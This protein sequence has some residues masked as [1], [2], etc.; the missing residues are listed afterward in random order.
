MI[1]RSVSWSFPSVKVEVGSLVGGVSCIRDLGNR[2][3]KSVD[4]LPF[5][6]RYIKQKLSEKGY[7]TTLHKPLRIYSS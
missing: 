3:E 1:I 5:S 2:K 6:R 7:H 4:V